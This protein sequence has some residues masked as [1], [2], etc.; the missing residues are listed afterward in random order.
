KCPH[1]GRQGAG[2]VLVDFPPECRHVLALAVEDAGQ[3]LRLAPPRLPGGIGEVG[4]VGLAAAR[5]TAGA[6]RPVAIRAMLP[7]KVAGGGRSGGR[8]G[9]RL[10]GRALPGFG[11]IGLRVDGWGRNELPRSQT[12]EDY[13]APKQAQGPN[14]TTGRHQLAPWTS[15]ATRWRGP[16]CSAACERASP[17]SR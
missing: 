7:V 11:G 2:L 4:D 6:G 1:V 8:R 14:G 17:A 3:E 12:Q 16:N 9:R 15:P 10:G 13:D 5:R